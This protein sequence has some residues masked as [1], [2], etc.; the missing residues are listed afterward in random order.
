MIGGAREDEGNVAGSWGCRRRFAAMGR[1]RNRTPA[2]CRTTRAR[3]IRADPRS[4]SR[5]RK[6]QDTRRPRSCPAA[7]RALR[8]RPGMRCSIC[9]RG[10]TSI[11]RASLRRG[12][13]SAMS[14]EERVRGRRCASLLEW[15][16]P[17]AMDGLGASA[18]ADGRAQST[19]RGSSLRTMRATGSSSPRRGRRSSSTAHLTRDTEKPK[20]LLRSTAGSMARAACLRLIKVSALAL[21]PVAVL[22]VQSGKMGVSLMYA[23][24]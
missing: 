9:R 7:I 8:C 1:S 3:A 15:I 11:I 10:Y 18:G 16:C 23:R 4:T 20:S 22:Y 19:P 17:S 13:S 6:S 21:H 2:A 24:L 14:R 12:R 5:S